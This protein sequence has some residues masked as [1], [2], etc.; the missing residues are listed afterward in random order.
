MINVAGWVADFVRVRQLMSTTLTRK[1]FDA[2]G[3]SIV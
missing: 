1:V 3:K 2:F